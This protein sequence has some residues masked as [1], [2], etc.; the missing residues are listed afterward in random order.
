VTRRCSVWYTDA[1]I[2]KRRERRP[3]GTLSGGMHVD[4]ERTTSTVCDLIVFV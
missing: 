4:R 3:F 2:W 1:R